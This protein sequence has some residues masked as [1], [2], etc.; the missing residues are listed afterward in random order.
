MNDALR[1]AVC[2]NYL[3]ILNHIMYNAVL[4]KI[5]WMVCGVCLIVLLC[6]VMFALFTRIM[7]FR[8]QFFLKRVF[9]HILS[10]RLSNQSHYN[11]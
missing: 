11:I 6:L 8:T 10:D 2:G 3:G 4:G 7:E 9:I 1:F 5:L